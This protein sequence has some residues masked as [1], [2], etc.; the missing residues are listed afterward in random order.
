MN[1]IKSFSFFL[2]FFNILN[3]LDFMFT[4][5]GINNYGFRYEQNG[6]MIGL[7]NSYG[8]NI[9][10]LIKVLGGFIVSI[11]LYKC[12]IVSLN[13]IWAVKIYN[14]FLIIISFSYFWVVIQHLTV[15]ILVNI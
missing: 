3:I 15:F 14:I 1:L 8:W 5:W 10:F 11:I 7:I 2:I 6:L 12:F 9:T 4:L 13:Y